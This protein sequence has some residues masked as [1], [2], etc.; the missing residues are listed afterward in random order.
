MELAA[1]PAGWPTTADRLLVG[2]L[3]LAA[4]SGS[5]RWSARLY[6]VLF[7]LPIVTVCVMS[8]QRLAQNGLAAY[9]GGQTLLQAAFASYFFGTL[10]A[11]MVVPLLA[12]VVCGRSRYWALLADVR[13]LMEEVA[14]S[15]DVGRSYKSLARRIWLLLAAELLQ[16]VL[17]ACMAYMSMK[18][19]VDPACSYY[20]ATVCFFVIAS[21]AAIVLLQSSMFMIPAKFLY[22]TLILG[23]G[24]QAVNTELQS[25]AGGGHLKDWSRLARLRSLQD[26]LSGTFSRLVTDMTPELI[27]AMVFGTI[28]MVITFLVLFQSAQDGTLTSNLP[29]VFYSVVGAVLLLA[30]PC[31]TGQHVLDLA[32][33]TR[34]SLLRLRW[35]GIRVGQEVG[36][37]LEAARRDLEHLGNLG[38]YRLQ[39]STMVAIISTVITYVIVFVQFS[40]SGA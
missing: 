4:Q 11:L 27:P 26:R 35:D 36:M 2:L 38:Y 1:A 8:S 18:A 19:T 30:V 5:T 14:R 40:T 21:Y 29:V 22:I 6:A 13:S 7:Y 20:N 25:L 12:T 28:S 34:D 31:E 17:V 32:A 10:Q 39:R 37:F 15:V 9:A 33:A 16:F 23:S 24:F 3:R